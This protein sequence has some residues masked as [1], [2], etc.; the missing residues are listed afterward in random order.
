MSIE[1]IDKTFENF[2]GLRL[3]FNNFEIILSLGLFPNHK[4]VVLDKLRVHDE[5]ATESLFLFN[6]FLIISEN[7]SYRLEQKI[8]HVREAFLANLAVS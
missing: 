5:L 4:G 7:W 1:N 8:L 3:F 2:T 6:F